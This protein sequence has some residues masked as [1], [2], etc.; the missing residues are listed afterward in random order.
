MKLDTQPGVPLVTTDALPDAPATVK[1][2]P[3]KSFLVSNKTSAA[4]V[5]PAAVDL[6]DFTSLRSKSVTSVTTHLLGMTLIPDSS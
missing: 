5:L 1:D 4:N 6:T 3:V 2:L